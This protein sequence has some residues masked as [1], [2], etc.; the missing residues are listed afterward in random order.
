MMRE[1]VLIYICSPLSAP[2]KD[3]IQKNMKKA[4][5]Y[6]RIVSEHLWCRAIAPHGFLPEYLN[7]MIPEERQIGLDF[8]LS[9]LGISNA[10]V[11]CGDLISSGMKGEITKA[12]ELGIPIY[13][14][15]ETEQKI[16]LV[17]MLQEVCA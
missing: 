10:V 3:G 9:I 16:E 7:D 11:V 2:T 14:L 17:D 6:A 1:E 12:K 4:A 15:I 8:G 5:W 13:M